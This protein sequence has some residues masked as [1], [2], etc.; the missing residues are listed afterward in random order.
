M[1]VIFDE[2]T[3]ALFDAPNFPVVATV[4]ED[5]SAHSSVVWAK[6]EGD[7]VLFCTQRN[8]IKG[9]NIAARPMVSV[10]VFDV[11]NPYRSAEV[12]GRA[13][14]TENDVQ[15]FLN[16]LSIKYT[17]IPKEPDEFDDL[18]V[19]IRVIVDKIVPFAL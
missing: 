5:G 2:M 19:V 7:T 10:S 3:S 11:E 4:S 8:N 12:R 14:F 15:E 9:R 1:A 18:C 6:R 17:G 13:E 16:E